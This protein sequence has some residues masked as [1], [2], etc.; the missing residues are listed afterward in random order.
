MAN[1]LFG[2]PRVLHTFVCA[3]QRLLMTK[4]QRPGGVSCGSGSVSFPPHFPSLFAQILSK[5]GKRV[6]TAGKIAT[7]I[8]HRSI[9]HFS[10]KL[11]SYL[12]KPFGI[13]KMIS[14]LMSFKLDRRYNLR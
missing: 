2:G 13:S 11:I 4:L 1:W 8:G 3:M 10:H 7:A 5:L 9:R 6:C 14:F 12:H